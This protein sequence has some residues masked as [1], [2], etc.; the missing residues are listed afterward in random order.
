ME[1]RLLN[2]SSNLQPE[3]D[4]AGCGTA[5][6]RDKTTRDVGLIALSTIGYQGANL[7]MFLATLKLAGTTLV[8]D[9]RE[10]AMSRRKEFAKSALSQALASVGIG[11][12][13]ERAVGTPRAV[14]QQYRADQNLN[15]F[16]VR[17]NDYLS[18][19]DVVLDRLAGTLR[20][21][22][23]LMCFERNPCEC[24]RSVVVAALADRLSVGFHHITVV[25]G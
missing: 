8:L 17:F 20:G 1:Q 7:D 2:F 18:T 13:H 25:P 14:R 23:T 5:S 24:H 9:V 3:N 22:V 4:G 12:R 21:R 19:Q 11:Y 15:S 10:R 16:F 6:D